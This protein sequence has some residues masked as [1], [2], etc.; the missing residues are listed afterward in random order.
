MDEK[1]EEWEPA[2]ILNA[3]YYNDFSSQN[4]KVLASVDGRYLGYLYIIDL[5]QDRPIKSIQIAKVPCHIVKFIEND[6]ILVCGYDDGS[7]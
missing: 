7:F 1:E 5:N 6:E 2:P 4:E 3:I